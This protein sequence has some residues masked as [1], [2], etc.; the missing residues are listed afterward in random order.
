MASSS[1]TS[2]HYLNPEELAT[3]M[4]KRFMDKIPEI[5]S[6][7]MSWNCSKSVG[8]SFEDFL[9][10]DKKLSNAYLRTYFNKDELSKLKQTNCISFDV[11]F[12]IK[13]L[14]LVC[15]QIAKIGAPE[16]LSTDENDIEYHLKI[17]KCQRNNVM[18]EPLG[19]AVDKHLIGEMHDLTHKLLTTAGAKFSRSSCEITKAKEKLDVIISEIKSTDMTDHEKRI[20]ECKRLIREEGLEKMRHNIKTFK[21]SHPLSKHITGF[22]NLE[23]TN[24]KENEHIECFKLLK[25]YN[26]G[27]K[28]RILFI[29]GESGLGKS[30]LMEQ[31]TED[32]LRN[33]KEPRKFEG[34]A[35][36]KIPLLSSCT[37]P[38]C[39][40][41]SELVGME[42]P[43][44]KAKGYDCDLILESI[45]QMEAILL[46]DGLDEMTENFKPIIEGDII[47]FLKNHV[48]ITCIFSSRPYSVIAFQEKL[49]NEGLSY[50]TLKINEIKSTE[51]QENFLKEVSNKGPAI[52]SSYKDSELN[53]QYPVCLAL[54]S[55]FLS[56]ASYSIKFSPSPT[57]FIREI[58]NYY[59]NDM[60]KRLRRKGIADYELIAGDI[61]SKFALVSF[62]CLMEN[63][64][65]LEA[66]E[67]N[68]VIKKIRDIC[69]K[70]HFPTKEIMSCFFPSISIDDFGN[71]SSNKVFLHKSHQEILASIYIYQ[72]IKKTKWSIEEI[73]ITAFKDYDR[74]GNVEDGTSHVHALLKR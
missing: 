61:L 56:S 44:L 42:F 12:I 74:S 28:N 20:V 25:Y 54:Y 57:H 16:W 32:I 35:R 48:E 7:V 65:E 38:N 46:I 67:V 6:I 71:A 24:E 13:L 30:T 31:I 50:E 72:Q 19:A 17:L 11:T 29:K 64:L 36:F 69:E 10:G 4:N 15:D 40:T 22:Y 58:V 63:K 27:L 37:K 43:D 26:D 73:C 53:L 45:G 70:I 55:Y 18:H 8:Q 2:L 23:L 3:L 9:K 62:C 49:S 59:L 1:T 34:S 47:N 52:A 51:E 5:L 41:L 66:T 60:K 33:N 21:D 68:W 14:P 39:K